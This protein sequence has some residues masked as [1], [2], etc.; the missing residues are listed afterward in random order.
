MSFQKTLR[1]AFLDLRAGQSFAYSWGHHMHCF[2]S[3]LEDTI[4]MADDTPRYTSFDHPGLSGMGQSRYCRSWD[5]LEAWAQEHTSC[6]RHINA[7]DPKFD[8]LL[9]YRYCPPGSPYAEAIRAVF[10]DVNM[11][12]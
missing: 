5:Q 3:L 8:T 10:G 7:T 12:E 6:W 11:E 1:R 2:E 4:C 9:R